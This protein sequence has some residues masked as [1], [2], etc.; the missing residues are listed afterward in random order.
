M[1]L[2]YYKLAISVHAAIFCFRPCVG[3]KSLFPFFSLRKVKIT[4]TFFLFFK[5]RRWEKSLREMWCCCWISVSSVCPAAASLVYL[6]WRNMPWWPFDKSAKIG[7]HRLTKPKT[8]H[9]ASLVY[10][11]ICLKYI[12]FIHKIFIYLKNTSTKDEFYIFLGLS[13]QWWAAMMCQFL[14]RWNI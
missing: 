14:W 10:I 13:Y 11:I 12:S 9:I 6:P 3:S 2:K 5:R 7:R 4:S 1:F 8:D